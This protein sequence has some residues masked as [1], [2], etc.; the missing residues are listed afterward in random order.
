M[1][2]TAWDQFLPSPTHETCLCC[3]AMSD[4]MKLACLMG[5]GR[6]P[7]YARLHAGRLGW[8]CPCTPANE[9]AGAWHLHASKCASKHAW[10]TRVLVCTLAAGGPCRRCQGAAARS[11]GSREHP[12][13]AG[14]EVKAAATDWHHRL[15]ERA[16]TET[17]NLGSVTVRQWP[18]VL[19]V[20][21]DP[22][23]SSLS[24]PGSG[25]N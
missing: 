4:S 21:D 9:F 16:A 20:G 14:V 11:G 19:Q 18:L 13:G 23:I 17:S 5:G 25:E 2:R 24:R 15:H 8:T 6:G 12:G 10:A 3:P 1:T 22:T 7:G